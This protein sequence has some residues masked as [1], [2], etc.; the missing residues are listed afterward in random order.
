MSRVVSMFVFFGMIF[1]AGFSMAQMTDEPQ[2]VEMDARDYVSRL[3]YDA[4]KVQQWADDADQKQEATNFSELNRRAAELKGLLSILDQMI[5]AGEENYDEA[6]F[7]S[8]NER[9]NRTF[10]E[11]EEIQKLGESAIAQM[12]KVDDDALLNQ[13]LDDS[14]GIY[15]SESLSYDK[16][17]DSDAARQNIW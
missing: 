16:F 10:R 13:E 6:T 17:S 3:H 8:A 1:S 7:A 4:G 11:A 14:N 12:K 9:F 5:E 15:T 2:A